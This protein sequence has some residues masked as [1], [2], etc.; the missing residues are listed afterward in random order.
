[1]MSTIGLKY[2]ISGFDEQMRTSWTKELNFEK[3]QIGIMGY[4]VRESDFTLIYQVRQQGDTYLRAHR[5]DASANLK[6]SVTLINMGFIVFFPEYEMVVSED[7]NKVLFY[8][9]DKGNELH[10]FVLDNETMDL[11]YVFFYTGEYI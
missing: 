6:D 5:Y 9:I 3:K 8:A 10:A 11:L 2:E 7:R 1:M 4:N